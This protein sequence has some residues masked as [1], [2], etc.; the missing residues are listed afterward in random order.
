MNILHYDNVLKLGKVLLLW[1]V[2]LLLPTVFEILAVFLSPFIYA[3]MHKIMQAD[4]KEGGRERER[5][6]VY[7]N[8]AS[9]RADWI[10]IK[11]HSKQYPLQD[12]LRE[13]AINVQ[14]HIA[15]TRWSNSQ[16]TLGNFSVLKS[17]PMSL[18]T[19]NLHFSSRYCLLFSTF[20]KYVLWKSINFVGECL[21]LN[22]FPR[23]RKDTSQAPHNT[24][25]HHL[26][27]SPAVRLA[28]KILYITIYSLYNVM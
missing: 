28:L 27:F 16:N 9:I 22:L 4:R 15:Q 5:D 14:V 17:W 25:K 21:H 2:I 8:D 19:E 3:A 18:Q 13:I 20:K 23:V 24:E 10:Q 6:C 7:I 11:T 1:P 12:L 26:Q